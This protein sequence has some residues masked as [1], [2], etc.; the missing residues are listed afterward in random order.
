MPSDILGRAHIRQSISAGDTYSLC[1]A[2]EKAG[3]AQISTLDFGK[4]SVRVHSLLNE[5]F[6]SSLQRSQH[7]QYSVR[8]LDVESFPIHYSPVISTIQPCTDQL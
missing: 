3:L 2:T 4:L 8:P 6:R 5:I 1:A 7:C